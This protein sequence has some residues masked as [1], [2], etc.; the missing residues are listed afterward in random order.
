M[1]GKD[2]TL[3][4]VHIELFWRSAK[5]EKIYPDPPDEG[6]GLYQIIRGYIGFY[7]NQRR[8]MKIGK[9]P[10]DQKFYNQK[11]VG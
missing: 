7:N 3:D 4:N 5:Q 1:D 6:V 10:P 2:R 9:I 8:H 11:M